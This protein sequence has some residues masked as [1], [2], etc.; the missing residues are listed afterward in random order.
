[1]TTEFVTR[2]PSP[3]EA[4]RMTVFL[5]EHPQWSATWDKRDGV[6]RVAEDDPDSGLYA[7]SG[8]VDTVLSYMAV[9]S[10]AEPPSRAAGARASRTSDSGGRT[11]DLRPAYGEH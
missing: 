3:G 6:W 9:H 11:V 2:L 4:A 5:R 10:A 7:E 8:D 1:M